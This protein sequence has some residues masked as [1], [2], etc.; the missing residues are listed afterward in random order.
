[1]SFFNKTEYIIKIYIFREGAK[2][3]PSLIQCSL[4]PLVG[5][6]TY[7]FMESFIVET[8]K[9]LKF[10][11]KLFK[12]K[13]LKLVLLTEP[14]LKKNWNHFSIFPVALVFPGRWVKS[15]ELSLRRVYFTS[16]YNLIRGNYHLLPHRRFSGTK[17]ELTI[18]IRIGK[19]K[20]T[21]FFYYFP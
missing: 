7:S 21:V 1:M 10:L 19:L 6:F 18:T 2:S 17:F 16:S 3:C 13:I 5:S 8:D 20:N 9:F 15:I 11:I 14:G 12:G 4:K